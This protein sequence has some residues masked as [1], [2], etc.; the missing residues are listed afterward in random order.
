VENYSRN[1]LLY[2]PNLSIIVKQRIL[3][4]SESKFIIGSKAIYFI[5]SLANRIIHWRQYYACLLMC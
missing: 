1:N 4:K 3:E 2:C 5:N